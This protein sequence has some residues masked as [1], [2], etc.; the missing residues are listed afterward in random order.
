M[1]KTNKKKPSL[2][3]TSLT[4]FLQGAQATGLTPS[5]CASEVQLV[6]S[7]DWSWGVAQAGPEWGRERKQQIA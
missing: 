6:P 4:W 7:G 1:G 3:R 2:L 5:E